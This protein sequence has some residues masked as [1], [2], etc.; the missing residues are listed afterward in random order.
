MEYQFKR[1]V[2][3]PSD[4]M[5]LMGKSERTVRRIIKEIRALYNK[6]KRAPITVGEF[7][8]YSGYSVEEVRA[9]LG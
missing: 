7:C 5:Q 3:Y 1:F 8:E 6:K 9:F 4:I 2:L